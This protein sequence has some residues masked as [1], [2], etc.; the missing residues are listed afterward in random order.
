MSVRLFRRFPRPPCPFEPD[1]YWHRLGRTP[2]R[3]VLDLALD[4]RAGSRYRIGIRVVR[5]WDAGIIASM[6]TRIV[7]LEISV[8]LLYF[9]VFWML[10]PL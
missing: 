5:S 6:E 3:P 10:V 9:I 7:I 1:R 4:T 2:F 8:L